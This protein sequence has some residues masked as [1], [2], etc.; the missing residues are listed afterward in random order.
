MGLRPISKLQNIFSEYAENS[1]LVLTVC[2]RY[3][4]E[5][6]QK[7]NGFTVYQSEPH[8]QLF[9]Y[10]VHRAVVAVSTG[11]DMWTGKHLYGNLRRGKAWLGELGVCVLYMLDLCLVL[12]LVNINPSTPVTL[13]TDVITT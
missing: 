2:T 5:S 8:F 3:G 7:L 12:Q 6:F 11:G 4:Y 10:A 13:A 9:V 1:F